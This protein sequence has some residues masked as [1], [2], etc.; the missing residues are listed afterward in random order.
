MVSID[1]SQALIHLEEACH[2]AHD[3][4][5]K[6]LLSDADYERIN[7]MIYNCENIIKGDE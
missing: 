1:A 2:A 6:G 3:M 7:G 4:K 5:R